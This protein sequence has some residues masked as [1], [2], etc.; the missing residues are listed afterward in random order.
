MAVNGGTGINE[1]CKVVDI[2]WSYEDTLQLCAAS[3]L[4]MKV[5][6]SPLM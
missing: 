6:I 5:L 3:W 2:V 1:V 4:W